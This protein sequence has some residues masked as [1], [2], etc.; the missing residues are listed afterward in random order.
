M[1]NGQTQTCYEIL[2]VPKNASHDEI[3][4]M[5]RNCFYYNLSCL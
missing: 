3:K 2:G 5:Y 4:K 1:E